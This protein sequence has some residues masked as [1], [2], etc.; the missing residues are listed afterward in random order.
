MNDLARTDYLREIVQKLT[1]AKHGEKGNII[2]KA[3]DTLQ[4]SRPQLYRELETVGFESD[5]KTRCD[6]GK[7]VVPAEVAEQVGAMVHLATRANGKKTL[8]ISTALEILQ[9]DGKVPKVS[10]ATISRV[11]KANMCHP[12]QLATPTAHTRMRSLHPN[13]LWQVDASVCVIFYLPKDK[14]GR[15]GGMQIMDEKKFYKNKPHNLKKIENERV[16]RYVITDHY[17]GWVYVEYVA[18]AESSE[19]LTQVFLNAIQIRGFDEPMHGVPFILY[20]DKG[21]A[22]TSGLFK[23]LMERLD[24]TFIAHATGNSRAKGQVENANN[25]VETQFEGRFKFLNIENIE[26]LNALAKRWR[27]D[28]NEH[29]KHSRTKRTRNEVWR[30]IA[31][32]QLRKAPSMELC[33]ELVSTVPVERTVRGNLTISHSVKGYGSHDYDLRHIN[34]IYPKAKVSVVVNPYRS[35]CVDVIVPTAGGESVTYTVEPM[36]TDWVGF[37]VNAPVVGQEIKA[38]P[39]SQIDNQ[40]NKA[41]K[42]AYGVDTLEKAELAQAKKAVAYDGK[43]NIMADI[44]SHEQKDY[45]PKGGE[46]LSTP[47][48]D[49]TPQSRKL[50]PFNWV[51]TA[52]VIRAEIGD[53]WTAEH[54]RELQETF[55][56]GEVPQEVI[57][58]IIKGILEPKETEHE[59]DEYPQ[60]LAG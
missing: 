49:R 41:I 40:R 17:S 11:M 3:C 38:M 37:D 14:Q 58:E 8:P 34:G 7:T 42:T 29:K 50:A 23:N 25:I 60:A 55:P 12:K 20:A 16:I 19:N 15:G 31:V 59:Y 18:G 2:A 57:S 46:K 54:Y 28:Y 24:I 45:M 1:H 21:C 26:H 13:H 53:K 30:T 47:A 33:K 27:V 10:P 5:R 44:D 4:I 32:N 43:L 9:A 56:T 48:I 35:P 52:K 39:N 51:Q 36:Q 6:K 22:N